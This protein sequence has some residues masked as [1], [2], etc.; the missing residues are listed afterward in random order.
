[1]TA[2]R[3]YL[4]SVASAA[5]VGIC[6]GVLLHGRLA[7]RSADALALPALHGEAT[8]GAGVRPAPPVALRDQWG[9]RVSLARLRGRAATLLF[10][11]SL[12]RE[13][14]PVEGRLLAAA[15]RPLAPRARPHVVVVSV[16]PAGDTPASIGKAIRK[17]GLPASTEW[18]RGTRAQLAR[19]WRAYDITVDPRSSDVVH[20]T[21]VYVLDAHGDE[22]AGFVLPFLPGLVRADLRAL[23]D[24]AA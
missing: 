13:A 10:M 8:W 5:V 3:L 9:R 4:L 1:M 11:D 23:A 14:C 7:A 17:W 6:L 22:R 2:R 18:L 15:I 19:V 16:D 12:C 20:S 21:A 24:G